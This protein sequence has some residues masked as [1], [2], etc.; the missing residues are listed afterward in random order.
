[1]S[2]LKDPIPGANMLFM[3]GAKLEGAS[4]TFQAPKLHSFGVT[5]FLVHDSLTLTIRGHSQMMSAT[6]GRGRSQPI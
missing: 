6:K 1:M 3:A 5:S 2:D 4:Y